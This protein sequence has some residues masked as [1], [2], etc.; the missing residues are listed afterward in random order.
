MFNTD[1]EN[2]ETAVP[3]L[4]GINAQGVK[5][6]ALAEVEAA[7]FMAKRFPRDEQQA[8][9]NIMKSCTRPSLAEVAVYEYPRGGTK[10]TGPSIRL[11]EAVA[12]AWGNIQ[13]G[14]DELE[15][16]A[17]V[18]IVKAYA[19]DIES[20]VKREINFS[21]TH[22][23]DTKDGGYALTS[24]RDIY[25]LIANQSMRRVRN[26]ILGVIP[27][28]IID[29]AMEKCQNTLKNG[30]K[31]PLADRIR[32]MVSA[33]ESDYQV[34]V[35]MLEAYI[36]CKVEAFTENDFNRLKRVYVS[37]RDGMVKREE[38]FDMNAGAKKP[39]ARLDELLDELNAEML[40][41]TQ[42]KPQNAAKENQ[43]QPQ[44]QPSAQPQAQTQSQPQKQPPVQTR[45]QT[46]AQDQTQMQLQVQDG[47]SQ[48]KKPEGD[49]K[50]D[51]K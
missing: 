18:S 48:N 50:K 9:N 16:S 17:G 22:K 28:D 35:P 27:G 36:G 31:E 10:V 47:A 1:I 32:S 20:N 11:A 34:K 33:F 7:V 51:A 25:E 49:G 14:F 39:D 37:L 24:E 43:S 41:G 46:Q 13:Y 44:N 15:R 38:V 40:P 30:H 4:E 12:T 29:K 23:R 5:Q 42:Q 3:K 2:Y 21:V 45:P 26:C 19:W 6:K 8:F